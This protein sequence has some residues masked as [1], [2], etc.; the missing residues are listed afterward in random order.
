MKHGSSWRWLA[1][2]LCGAAVGLAAWVGWGKWPDPKT[3]PLPWQPDAIVI[4][5]GGDEARSRKGLELAKAFPE[6]ALLVTGDGGS[7]V[8][9]LTGKGIPPQRIQHEE[10][11]TS[12]MENALLTDPVLDGLNSQ[13][14]VLVTNWFHVPRSLAIF[15][16][17]QP[18]REWCVA[19]EPSPDPLTPWD[20]GCRRRERL[21]ALHHFLRYGLWCF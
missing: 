15:R 1:L 6:A 2:L 18:E 9:Y 8:R 14:A 11:A 17:I 7:I 4:L 10:A 12:T 13:H 19:F 20:Q 21:A 16:S 5:G 3:R